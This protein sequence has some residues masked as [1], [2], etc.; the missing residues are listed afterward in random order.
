MTTPV[1]WQIDDPCPVC[2][3]ALILLDDGTS[4]PRTECR[5]C[6][7]ADTWTRDVDGGDQ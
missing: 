3:T 7:R 2:A 6:G 4:L 1:A 5:Q